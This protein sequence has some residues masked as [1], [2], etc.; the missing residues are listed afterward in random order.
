MII[1]TL[2]NSSQYIINDDLKRAFD[3]L[4]SL[5]EFPEPGRVEVL[6]NRIYANFDSYISKP[7][8]ECKFESHKRY[9]DIQ[10]LFKGEEIIQ[11]HPVSKMDISIPYNAEKDIVF[12]ADPATGY[13]TGV[14][15]D[16]IFMIFYPEDAHKPQ[17]FL[18]SPTEIN[19]VVV[20]II[21][22]ECSS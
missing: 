11:W 10:M 13:D 20:K 6:Q 5:K 14:L 2:N 8:N 19:K 18:K 9:I 3:F 17:I 21:L 15:T 22:P 16:D 1:D 12:Y 4:N 7:E